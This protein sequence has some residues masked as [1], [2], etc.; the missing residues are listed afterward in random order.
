M[1][2]IVTI[3]WLRLAL[4]ILAA[5]VCIV[6]EI[7]TGTITADPAQFTTRDLTNG[8]LITLVV[9]MLSYYLVIKRRFMFKVEKPQKLFTTGIGIYFLSWLVFWV[10]L[11]TIIAVALT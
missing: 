9:Y 11:Y 6:F 3:Y 1:N 4:G 7:V 5:L 2:T 8:I 10:F